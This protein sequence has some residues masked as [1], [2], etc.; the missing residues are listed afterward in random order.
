MEGGGGRGVCS[1]LAEASLPAEY[2]EK[3]DLSQQ[4]RECEVQKMLD[5]FRFLGKCPPTPPLSHHSALSEK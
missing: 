2:Q 1:P 4:G 5:Q 3:R